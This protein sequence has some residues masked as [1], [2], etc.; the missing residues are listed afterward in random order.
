VDEFVADGAAGPP[1]TEHGL[2]SIE[3][4]L[5]DFTMAR[6][7]REQQR[8]PRPAAFPDAHGGGV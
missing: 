3:T 6:L 7:D 4:Q 2:V 5:A 8:L 1:A